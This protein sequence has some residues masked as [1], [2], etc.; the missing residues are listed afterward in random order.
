MKKIIILIT[1]LFSYTAHAQE[2]KQEASSL[3]ADSSRM[4]LMFKPYADKSRLQ[5]ILQKQEGVLKKENLGIA[6]SN[7]KG[8]TIIEVNSKGNFAELKA[9]KSEDIAYSLPVFRSQNQDVLLSNEL[10]LE[11]LPQASI[12][13][14][15]AKLGNEVTLTY[16]SDWHT[17]ILELKNVNNILKFYQKINESGLVKFCVPNTIADI[18]KTGIPND[19][20]FAQQYYLKNS[21]GIDINAVPAWDISTGCNKVTVAMIDDGVE[22]HEDLRDANG[23]SRVL[24]G[25]TPRY[26]SGNG[27]PNLGCAPYGRVGHGQSCAGIMGATQNN[28]IGIS[29]IASN[30]QIVPVNIFADNNRSAATFASDVAEGIRWASNKAKILS[31]SWGYAS[32]SKTVEEET[33]IREAITFARNK[34]CILIFGAGNWESL[35]RGVA[36]P[37][38]VEGVIAVGAIGKDGLITSYSN[39]GSNGLDL[40]AFGGHL[41]PPNPY[42]VDGCFVD[43]NGDIVT[44]D[45]MANQG[46]SITQNYYNFFSGTSA[47]CP[48]VSGAVALMLSIRPNL[49]ETQIT[50]I[51]R[52]TAT[53]INGQANFSDIYGYGRLNVGAAL[54]AT[55][56]L[57]NAAFIVDI[58]NPCFGRGNIQIYPQQATLD[59]TTSISV[60]PISNIQIGGSGALYSYK[61]VNKIMAGSFRVIIKSPCSGLFQQE[62]TVY[63]GG[64]C[65]TGIQKTNVKDINLFPNPSANLTTIELPFEG[66][67]STITIKN[68]QGEVIDSFTTTETTFTFDVSKYKQGLYTVT[69]SNE[70][71]TIVKKL[72]VQIAN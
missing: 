17:Y 22:D 2:Y 50:D 32:I 27:R 70:V 38:N 31:N 10:Y 43:D 26:P 30:V 44:L 16:A 45:R 65:A 71:T 58:S 48:Q 20:L 63:D 57:P 49:T 56:N 39:R 72:Q 68:M 3:V 13:T 29:G 51:L 18:V 40:V 42:M 47:A 61:I 28:G 54:Q 1:V 33:P 9:L 14:L 5:D 8:Y 15:L 34:G 23:N 55:N 35:F 19:P 25:F 21:T 24:A 46:Y 11:L 4:V 12:K 66:I 69:V 59:A 62:Y 60:V 6:L 37:A 41:K 7:N 64:A 52:N 36:F 67:I 53:K